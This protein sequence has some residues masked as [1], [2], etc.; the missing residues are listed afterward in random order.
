MKKQA[1]LSP[2]S[3]WTS[4]RF[5]DTS[6]KLGSV[7]CAFAVAVVSAGLG[8]WIP[9]PACIDFFVLVCTDFR[10]V[11]FASYIEGQLLG[12]MGWGS[13]AIYGGQ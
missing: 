7:S 5:F 9:E 13:A 12:I 10:L 3:T 11:K 2:V 8:V 1:A 4:V 6:L